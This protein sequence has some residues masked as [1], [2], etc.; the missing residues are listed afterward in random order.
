MVADEL[1]GD[2]NGLFSSLY[3]AARILG[4]LAGAGMYATWGGPV[5][6]WADIATFAL[7]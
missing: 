5:V 3:Q 1:L 7:T 2:A 6:V 4:P